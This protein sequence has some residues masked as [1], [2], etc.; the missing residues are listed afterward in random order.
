MR[1]LLS[2]SFGELRGERGIQHR[3][4]SSI[5]LDHPLLHTAVPPAILL[6]PILLSFITNLVLA[7]FL[8]PASEYILGS[9]ILANTGI[10]YYSV[11]TAGSSIVAEI[12]RLAVNNAIFLAFL[13]MWTAIRRLYFHPLSKFPGPKIRAVTSLRE[14]VDHLNGNWSQV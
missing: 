4:M 2:G 14:T 11:T 12:P 5:L 3:N 8:H 9:Y 7:Q 6:T 10:L 1:P 13:A